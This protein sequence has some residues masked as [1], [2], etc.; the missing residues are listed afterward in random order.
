MYN[1]WTEGYTASIFI[2]R[3]V[4]YYLQRATRRRRDPFDRTFGVSSKVRG[5]PVSYRLITGT[6]A[7]R[8]GIRPQGRVDPCP[9]RTIVKIQRLLSNLPA[10]STPLSMRIYLALLLAR[11]VRS[12]KRNAV[13]EIAGEIADL[14]SYVSSAETNRE[15]NTSATRNAA[16]SLRNTLGSPTPE[17]T[18]FPFRTNKR[19][20]LPGIRKVH[21]SSSASLARF[22]DPVPPLITSLP[23]LL[24]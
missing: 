8:L 22:R 7:T 11:S 19:S 14:I 12:A 5:P 16:A 2:P 6:I 21:C 17:S 20:A 9:H 13:R 24:R 23:V 18:R 1:A 10:P 4:I 3:E 15:K